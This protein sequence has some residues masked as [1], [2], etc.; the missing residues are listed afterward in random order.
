MGHPGEPGLQGPAGEPGI[1]GA[2]GK[3]GQRVKKKLQTVYFLN[4]QHNF[5]RVNLDLQDLKVFKGQPDNPELLGLKAH[6]AFL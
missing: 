6:L 1:P 4:C 3:E 5:C 2:A